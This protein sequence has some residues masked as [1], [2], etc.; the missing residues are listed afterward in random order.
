[1]GQIFEKWP[2]PIRKI[3]QNR[4]TLILEEP[5]VVTLGLDPPAELP[6]GVTREEAIEV[7]AGSAWAQNLAT[8]WLKAFMP[9]LRPGTP[10]YEEAHKRIARRVAE[11]VLT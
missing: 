2:K 5:L 10:E 9:D 6:P 1:M 11:G 8:G 4:P 7:I 3:L